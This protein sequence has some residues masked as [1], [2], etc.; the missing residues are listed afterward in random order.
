MTPKKPL[1]ALCPIGK[2][3]FSNADAVRHKALIQQKLRACGVEFVDLDGVLEDGLVKDQKHVEVAVDFFKSKNVDALFMPHCNFGTEG[4]VGM[5]A[6]HLNLPTLIWGP[7]DGAPLADGSR[8]RDSLCGLFASTKVLHKLN[9]PFTYIE[10]CSVD[11]AKFVEGLDTFVRAAAVAKLFRKGMKIGQV[12]LRI[13]FFWSTIINESELLEKF[14]V[15]VVPI[16]LVEFINAAKSRSK[17]NRAAYQKEA[18]RLREKFVVEGF[19]KNEEPLLNILAAR[20]E[21]LETAAARGLDGIAFQPFPSFMNSMEAYG[22]FMA[23]E[24]SESYAF[25]NETDIHGTIS[26]LMTQAADLNMNPSFLAEFTNRHPEN[27]NGVLLWHGS[28][29]FSM[30]HPDEQARIGHHWIFPSPVSGM[31]HMRLKDGPL[32]M[33][34]FDGDRGEYKLAVGEGHSTDGP[35]TQNSYLWAEVNDWPAWE[36]TLMEGPFIHHVAMSYGH[37]S[38]ALI[39]ACKYIPGLDPVVL[40]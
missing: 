27:D 25:G 17:A 12:G 24:V 9:I 22:N 37:Y 31:V 38:K 3:V 29:P 23:S 8:L 21:M 35:K 5:I 4:A 39:E 32:T 26:C 33:A 30:L 20:D 15:Q 10:N 7:R 28:A 14:N 2:F 19:D 18:M 11:D 36:R 1:V 34:R 16:D 13:D 40:G 6:K